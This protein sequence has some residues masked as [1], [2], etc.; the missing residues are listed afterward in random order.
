MKNHATILRTPV[1]AGFSGF[2]SPR[3]NQE[4][5]GVCQINEKL[6]IFPTRNPVRDTDGNLPPLGQSFG[7]WVHAS[8]NGK[9]KTLQDQS[10]VVSSQVASIVPSPI[11]FIPIRA[12]IVIQQGPVYE[13]KHP[14][15]KVLWSNFR[16]N[17]TC[18]S[19]CESKRTTCVGIEIYVTIDLVRVWV[20]RERFEIM[21][22]WKLYGR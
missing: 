13:M 14:Y 11:G 10:Q 16:V 12:A 2:E 22:L 5:F 4:G 6:W 3:V 17:Q 18:G 1:L 8:Q 20:L 15:Q 21:I 7:V 19:T 9:K